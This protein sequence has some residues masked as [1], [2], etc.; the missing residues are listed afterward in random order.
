[1]SYTLTTTNDPIASN[2]KYR[3]RIQAV[4]E[5]GDSGFSE[6]VVLIIAPLPSKFVAVTK[7]QTYS[8]STSIMVRWTDPGA[9]LAPILGYKLKMTD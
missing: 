6:E 7:D 4:N 8:S 2:Q 9:E 3:F 5:Y 1:M